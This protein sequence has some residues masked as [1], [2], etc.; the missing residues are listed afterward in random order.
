MWWP[1]AILATF[2]VVIIVCEFVSVF[3]PPVPIGVP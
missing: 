1:A 3:I 2:V